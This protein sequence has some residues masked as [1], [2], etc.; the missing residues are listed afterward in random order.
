MS[1]ALV[2]T[3]R[4]LYTGAAALAIASVGIGFVVARLLSEDPPA[5]V[6]HAGEKI[7]YW[8]DP[9]VPNQRFDRP[10]KSPYMDMELVPK[11]ADEAAPAGPGVSIPSDRLQRLGVRY[12]TVQRGTLDDG[13]RV[14]GTV[15]FNQRDIAIVQSRTAGFVQRVYARAPGDI[16]GAGAPL[17]DILVPEWG[18]AQREYLAVR[19]TGNPGLTQAARQRLLLLGMSPSLVASVDR[20]GRVRDVVSIASP[21]GGVIKTL[22]VR[23]GMTVAAGQ[24]LAEVNGLGTVWV[25][26][27]V[28]EALA[29]NVRIGAPA[30]ALFAAYPGEPF[31]GRITAMLPEA[32]AA[33]RTLTVRVELANSGLR[34]RPGMFATVELAGGT[35]DALLVPSEAVIR[36]GKRNLVMLARS[37]GRFLPAQVEIGRESGG[38]TEIL[39][40]LTEGERIVASGQ[41]LIDSEASL[42]SI[43]T[44][45]ISG[46]NVPSSQAAQ[47]PIVHES[48]GRIELI[49]RGGI[50]ISHEPVLAIRWP[51]MT[52]RFR[53]LDS[54]LL[55][56]LKRGQRVRFAFDQPPQGPTLRRIAVQATQ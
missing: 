30:R 37:G 41:F 8:Y 46:P 5:A 22:G 12:A 36:T 48:A 11:Y 40:G 51:A 4:R 9:M 31:A 42:A 47:R 16:I 3:R 33:S 35:G 26:A 44:R 45:P 18:G 2:V 14:S 27:A 19:R 23:A 1:V 10:G 17:A 29:S 34:L 28:P 21:A 38:Q 13:V 50:T 49:E 24:T 20:T 39:A 6:E 43:E 15:D 54:A 7:L 52:M 53:V 55:R 56:G 32:Q 25:N